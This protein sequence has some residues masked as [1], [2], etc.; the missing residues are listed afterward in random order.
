MRF[1]SS[2]LTLLA[3]LG[4]GGGFIALVGWA[5]FSLHLAMQVKPLPRVAPAKALALFKSNRDAGLLLAAGLCLDPAVRLL[6][7]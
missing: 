1:M 4:V 7:G 6:F 5:A 3:I 2:G